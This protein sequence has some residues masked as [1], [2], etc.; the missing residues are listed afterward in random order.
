MPDTDM[1]AWLTLLLALAS[2]VSVLAGVWLGSWMNQRGA[3]KVATQTLERQRILAHDTLES[4]RILARDVALEDYRRQ[5]ITPYLEAARQ[6]FH[7]WSALHAE[8][9]LGDSAKLLEL[10]A[11][12]T[13]PHFNSL[14][15]TYV[16]IPDDTFRAAFHTFVRA[17]GKFKPTP[18]D[19]ND[20]TTSHLINRW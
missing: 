10:Q 12:L 19:R 16:E 7:I 2:P 20:Y 5:Q 14:F 17:E 15:A 11:Q 3:E 13:D 8:I 9:G 1:P 18:T 6:R 4:Q